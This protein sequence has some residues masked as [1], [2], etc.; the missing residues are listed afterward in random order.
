[1]RRDR[2]ASKLPHGH[3]RLM[4][5]ISH[6]DESRGERKLAPGK[7]RFLIR[8][9]AL[10]HKWH[11]PGPQ[12]AGGSGG[13]R[14]QPSQALRVRS[15]PRAAIGRADGAGAQASQPPGSGE[16][17]RGV[18]GAQPPPGCTSF[19]PPV[20]PELPESLPTG[21]TCPIVGQSQ[22]L[23]AQ[24]APHMLKHHRTDRRPPVYF[25]T[26]MPNTG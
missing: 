13:A 21:D 23:L 19:Q 25:V 3:L 16:Q 9:P 18:V 17:L 8:C 11:L 2:A 5:R 24:S 14:A 12:V 4:K 1:M 6:R 20:P 10:T 26:S 22:D 15:Q 7:A